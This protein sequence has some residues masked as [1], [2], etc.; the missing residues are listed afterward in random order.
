MCKTIK[1]HRNKNYG[2]FQNI[3]WCYSLWPTHYGLDG[4]RFQSRWWQ[5]IFSSLHPYRSAPGPTQWVQCVAELFPVCKVTGTWRWPLAP[6]YR[7]DEE[8]VELYLHSSLCAFMPCH[9][10]SITFT[11]WQCGWRSEWSGNASI[12]EDVVRVPIWAFVRV[13]RSVC[14]RK[15][16]DSSFAQ[17]KTVGGNI[18]ARLSTLKYYFS[19]P[20]ILNERSITNH[21]VEPRQE[22]APEAENGASRDRLLSSICPG[23]L[24]VKLIKI[25]LWKFHS[26]RIWRL[27]SL[28]GPY[29]S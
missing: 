15:S 4:V 24:L 25:I 5:Q 1:T 3:Y 9:K 29:G 16:T 12:L 7:W 18:Y 14:W 19:V 22:V 13:L 8:W 6:T 17:A 21:A 23:S 2:H 26:G 11:R 27:Y 10:D 28:Q 20:C